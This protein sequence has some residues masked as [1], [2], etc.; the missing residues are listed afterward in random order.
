MRLAQLAPGDVCYLDS[1]R[2]GIRWRY[3]DGISGRRVV[4]LQVSP[5]WTRNE[6]TLRLAAYPATT[7]AF[8]P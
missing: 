5:D 1:A 7:A 8:E 3:D 6:V 4:V 2:A